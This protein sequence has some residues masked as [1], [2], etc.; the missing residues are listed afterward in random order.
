MPEDHTMKLKRIGATLAVPAVSA[1]VAWVGGYDFD[2]RGFWQAYAL[3]FVLFFMALV[4]LYPG[5]K[6]DR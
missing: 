4:W 6:A 2:E 3:A 5:W 1:A